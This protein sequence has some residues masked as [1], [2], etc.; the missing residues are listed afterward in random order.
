MLLSAL[1]A[2]REGVD[3]SMPWVLGCCILCESRAALFVKQVML[4]LLRPDSGGDEQDLN[5]GPSFR[6]S[7]IQDLPRM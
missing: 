4:L 6:N 2:K 3:L 1:G 5:L 7:G